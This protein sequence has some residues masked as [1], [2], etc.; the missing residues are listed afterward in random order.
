M[1]IYK[2]EFITF[3][4]IFCRL[5]IERAIS[6]VKVGSAVKPLHAASPLRSPVPVPVA[7]SAAK[8]ATTTAVLAPSTRT[9]KTPLRN[10]IL[11]RRKSISAVL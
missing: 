9:I 1:F 3:L 2:Y 10:E 8:A 11:A 7:G 4:I 6:P 5:S